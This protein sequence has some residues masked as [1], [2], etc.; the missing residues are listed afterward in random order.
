MNARWKIFIAVA[1]FLV[2]MT[3]VWLVTIRIQPE[4]GTGQESQMRTA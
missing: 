4:K 2:L 3:C 1:V